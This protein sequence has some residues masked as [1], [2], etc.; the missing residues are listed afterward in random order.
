MK[1]K[2]YLYFLLFIASITSFSCRPI[3]NV[4]YGIKQPSN[5]SEDDLLKYLKRK[6]INDDNIFYLKD[7]VAFKEVMATQRTIPEIE[8]YNK[9]GYFIP[10][11]DTGFCSAPG[12]VY[13][14]SICDNVKKDPVMTRHISERTKQIIPCKNN[15]VF[16]GYQ[17]GDYDYTVILLWATYTGRLNKDHV[18]VWEESIQ[19]AKGCKVRVFKVSEDVMEIW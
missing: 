6:S 14:R 3:L 19:Q 9:E 12:Y 8:V 5:K 18:R 1:S 2:S 11:K 10:Y 4:Y 17:P 13:L 16:E 15:K 7:T